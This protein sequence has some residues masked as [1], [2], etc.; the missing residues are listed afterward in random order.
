M[1]KLA[2]ALV[3][4]LVLLAVAVPLLGKTLTAQPEV[5]ELHARMPENG[6]WSQEVIHGQVN[7][8]IQ[9]RLTSDGRMGL[10]SEN[11]RSGRRRNVT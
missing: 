3:V 7:Q 11:V 2:K 8:P 5:I 9:L 6:G 10:P 4:I 1:E